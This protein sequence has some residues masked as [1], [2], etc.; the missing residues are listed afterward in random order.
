MTIEEIRALRRLAVT[1][2]SSEGDSTAKWKANNQLWEWF[3]SDPVAVIHAI[4]AAALVS[5]RPGGLHNQRL[6]QTI[7]N[8][9]PANQE[10]AA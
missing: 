5:A 10:A 6:H 2:T 3:R 4:E 9:R 8:L 1:A 7:N